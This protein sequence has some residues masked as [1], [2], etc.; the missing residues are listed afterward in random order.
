MRAQ[1]QQQYDQE[2]ASRYTR[3]MPSFSEW[4]AQRQQPKAKGGSLKDLESH[5]RNQEGEYGVKRLQRAADEIPGLEKMYSYDALRQAFSGDNAKALMTMNP[6]LFEKYAERLQDM[7]TDENSTRH[8]TSGERLSFDDYM[9]HLANIK[10][11]FS[12]VP[13]LEVERRKPK[14]LPSIEGHEGRHRSRVLT[15]KGVEKSLVQLLP[16]ARQREPMP[17]RYREDFIEAMKK[18]LGEKRLVT[19]EGRSLLPADLTAQEHRNLENRNLLAANRPQLPEIYGKGGKVKGPQPLIPKNTVKAYKLFRVH[20]EHPGKL[21]PLF[22]DANTPVEMNKWVDAKEGEMRGNKVKSKIG[23]LAYRPGWHA[24][25]L[26]IATHIGEK[27]HPSKTAPDRRPA[28]H[29]WAEVEM[30][31]DVDWQSEA[32]KRG[33]NA[34]GRVVPVKAH[35]TDQIPVGG[36]Y[37]YKTNPNMTGNWLIGGSMKVN[38]VL[39]DAEVARINKASGMSDLPR[40]KPFKKKSFGFA[41][42][43]TVAP[44]EWI[45]EEHVNH[46]P[47]AVKVMSSGGQPTIAQMMAELKDAAGNEPLDIVGNT[48][49]NLQGALNV[50]KSVPGNLKRMVTDPVEYARSLPEPTGEQLMN[51]FQPGHIGGFAGVIKPKGGNW[52]KGTTRTSGNVEQ[53]IERLRPYINQQSHIEHAQAGVASRQAKGE[54]T[55]YFQGMLDEANKRNAMNKWVKNNLQNYIKK[56]MGTP[57][58]PIRALHEQG[59]THLPK[60]L[61]DKTDYLPERDVRQRRKEA[62]FPGEGMGQSELAKKWENLADENIWSTKA[63]KLQAAPEQ[64]KVIDQVNKQ[65]DDMAMRINLKFNQDVLNKPDSRLTQSQRYKLE[66]MPVHKKAEILGDTEYEKLSRVYQNLVNNHSTENRLLAENNPWVSKVDPNTNLYSGVPSGLGFDHVIDILKQDI[67]SGRIRPEQLNKVSVSDAV[68]RTHE[69]DQEMARKM[70]EAQI[71]ATEGMPVHK[72]YPTGYKWIEL[73][74]PKELPKG[75]EESAIKGYYTDE[76]GKFQRHPGEKILEDALK[77]EG[78]TMGHCVGGYCPDVLEGRSRIYSLR[79]TKGE[80]HVTVE[81]QPVRGS[82]LGR[83]M[84]DLSDEEAE[85]IYKNPPQ[86]IVQIKGKQNAAPKADYLP[87]VQDFVKSGNWSDVGDLQNTGLIKHPDTGEYVTRAERQAEVLGESDNP[88]QNQKRGGKVHMVKGDDQKSIDAMKLATCGCDIQ[89]KAEGGNVQPT[90]AQMK[91]ALYQR[92][93]LQQIGVNEAPNMT[94][95]I[96]IPPVKDESNYP[97]PGGVATKSG[98]PIG[99][100]DQNQQQPGQQLMAQQP[101]QGMPGAPG[102]PPM[103]AQQGQPAPQGQTPPQGNMLSMT[104]Q[105]QTLQALGGA[106]PQSQGLKRGGQPDKEENPLL[107]MHNISARKLGMADKL[108]GLPV[109]SLAIV[110]PEHG[111]HSFGDISLIGHPEMASPSKENPV[112]ASDVYSPRF[113]SLNDEETKIYKGFTPSGNRRYVPLTLENAVKAMKGNV[114]GGESWNYGAGTVRSGITPQFK[115]KEQI[116]KSRKRIITNQEFKPMAEQ[117]QNMLFE[118][119]EKFHPHSIYGGNMFQH[120]SDFSDMLKEAGTKGIHHIRQWYKPTLPPELLQE[121]GEYLRHLRDMPTEYFEAKPQRGVRLNEFVG[122]VVPHEQHE[123]LAPLLNKHGI[124][125]IETYHGNTEDEKMKNRVD[126]LKKFQDHFFCY[127]G[128]VSNK[129][130]Q[131]TTVHKNIDT[132]RLA[133]TKKKAK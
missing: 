5:L 115:N 120:S 127:G 8:T 23:D 116:K 128:K 27:S 126:A 46:K 55:S 124:S 122:A 36:H 37:R 114:R 125:R 6:A 75:W 34:Q 13:F 63:S 15:G 18:E 11:G 110:N 45:A 51:M 98:M 74:Q 93:E 40:S 132:M 33:T 102:Q 101:P 106:Q 47:K 112:Y 96:Y 70:A 71:K 94:P 21:F 19:P 131:K 92:P 84:G 90:L 95:K 113:P 62:G 119:A 39:T 130:Q 69:F 108:G 26:P 100:V 48:K 10:G 109:P 30:P 17:R 7:F 43:G 81:V 68:R 73:A 133:L 25:D 123:Q 44:E 38:K 104:P 59:V 83:M 66:E 97:P 105:G 22:V 89:H 3:D 14:Y 88:I 20:P 78:D 35:I 58:D 53:G 117:T 85:A 41:S 91:M 67:E 107:V 16:T 60:D 111:F 64:A 12:S 82:E 4:L 79:D 65:L 42:G 118:L 56:E 99:G 61:L 32:T 29:A 28:N 24:G 103:G 72:E 76:S 57:E 1:L 54:D 129:S 49:R 31:D 80:P 87:Y 50:A 2:M 9:K 121:A 52:L 86:R 77:Y